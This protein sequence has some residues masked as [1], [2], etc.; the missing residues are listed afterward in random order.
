MKKFGAILV[1]YEKRTIDP[2]GSLS[3]LVTVLFITL[4][5]G[6]TASAQTGMTP[7]VLENQYILWTDSSSAT[8]SRSIRQ[9][10][11]IL[12]DVSNDVSTFTTVG[13]TTHYNASLVAADCEAIRAEIGDASLKCQ[14]NFV[15]TTS[16]MPNDTNYSSLYGMA[17]IGAPEAW[18]INTGDREIVVAV[19]DTGIDH[20]HPDLTANMW[21]NPGETPGNGIDDDENGYIDDIYGYDFYNDDSDPYDDNEHGTHCAGTIG[22]V[23]NNSQGVV[24]VNWRV[25]LMALKFLGATGSGNTFDAVLAVNYA[26]DNGARVINA[27]FGGGGYDAALENAVQR[28]E[29]NGVLFVAAAGNDGTNNDISPSY[30]A[31][32]PVNYLLSVAATNDADALTWFSNYGKSSVDVAAPGSAILSTVPGGGYQSLS[33]TSMA[34]P[35]VAGLAALLLAEDPSL[36]L[37]ELWDAI[38]STVD[39]ISDSAF[40]ASGGRINAATAISLVTPPEEGIA[41]PGE[42]SEAPPALSS[43]GDDDSTP[44]ADP[45]SI[46]LKGIKSRALYEGRFRSLITGGAAGDSVD[47]IAILKNRSGELECPLGEFPTGAALRLRGRANQRFIKALRIA[48]RPRIVLSEEVVSRSR[49]VKPSIM[50]RRLRKELSCDYL[51]ARVRVVP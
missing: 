24:G 27:S 16:V 29:D 46:S 35:H 15:Y 28:A 49:R 38:F 43:P 19:I 31:S 14:P 44:P 17:K 39:T 3:I 10:H 11:P 33:G 22:A 32:F 42:D 40:L 36:T 18:E 4:F 23:G 5:G 34:T 21:R 48:A 51:R 45:I 6:A 13:N 25:S 37:S 30:P 26:I 1:Y 9:E 7:R 8:S 20:T 41:P 2:L 50:Q 47:L 12:V